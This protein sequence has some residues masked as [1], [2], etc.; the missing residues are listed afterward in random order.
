[1]GSGKRRSKSHSRILEEV[2]ELSSRDKHDFDSK[3]IELY[4]RT[5]L[6]CYYYYKFFE[7]EKREIQAKDVGV[8]SSPILMIMKTTG[9]CPEGRLLNFLF[10]K[11]RTSNI[12]SASASFTQNQV[13]ELIK[14]IDDVAS[15]SD[16]SVYNKIIEYVNN[17]YGIVS[18][19]ENKQYEKLLN[20]LKKSNANKDF[21]LDEVYNK[22]SGIHE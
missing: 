18:V 20:D 3:R 13:N 8:L 4:Y 19:R 10:H 7:D 11:F 21:S 5:Y 17:N 1:M 12:Q 14:K 15:K 22:L 16:E 2:G 6:L 9:D